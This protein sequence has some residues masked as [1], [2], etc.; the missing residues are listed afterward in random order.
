MFD[1]RFGQFGI[2]TDRPGPFRLPFRQRRRIEHDQIKLSIDIPG[3]PLERIGLNGF[4][5]AGLRLGRRPV[6]LKIPSRG[7][8]RVLAEIE[9]SHRLRATARGINRK[10]TGEAE[11]V[12]HCPPMC[13]RFHQPAVLPLVEKETSLLS[14]PHIRLK[15][16]TGFTEYHR[17]AGIRPSPL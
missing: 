7:F 5:S 14:A 11:R 10:S 17:S 15:S 2:S 9:V 6:E 12:E 13:Q 1:A 8:Q 16:Q 3:Q 4:M